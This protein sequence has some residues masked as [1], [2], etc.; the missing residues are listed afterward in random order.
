MYERLENGLGFRVYERLE[1]GPLLVTQG[2]QAR[3]EEGENEHGPLHE[4][5]GR[6]AEPV[7]EEMRMVSSL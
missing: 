2:A 7:G 4:A 6:G 3:K 1:N 5:Q